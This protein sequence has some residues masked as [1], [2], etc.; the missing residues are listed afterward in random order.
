MSAPAPNSPNVL[1]EEISADAQHESA[2]IIRQAR[3]EATSL[4]AA[5][6]AEA[7]TKRREYRE[8]ARTE[9]A[10]R[11]EL[12]LAAVAVEIVRYRAAH[13]ESLL[14]SVHAEIRRQL[15]TPNADTGPGVFALAAQ[16]IGRMPGDAFAVKISEADEAALGDHLAGEIIRRTGRTPQKLV[17]SADPALARGDVLVADANGRLF[18]DNRLSAR[19]DRLWPELRRQIAIATALAEKS[20]TS[21][22]SL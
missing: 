20:N 14:E 17:V 4:L 16:A 8:Q 15:L 12:I 10:R 6:E 2:E 7:E 9:A 13:V 5:A 22:G 21:G 3:A 1:C 11:R 19:L 18:W